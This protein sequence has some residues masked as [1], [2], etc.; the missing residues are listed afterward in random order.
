MESFA[1]AFQQLASIS[2]VLGGLAFTGAAAIL[3]AGAAT[4]DPDVVSRSAEVTAGTAVS[5]AVCFIAAAV[6]WSLMA[7]DVNRAIAAGAAFPDHVANVNW[8]PSLGLLTGTL[9]LLVSIGASGWIASRR[10]GRVTSVVAVVG[11]VALLAIFGWFAE[12]G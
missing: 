5:G 1:E 8:I 11:G 3:N 6:M 12:V 10:L 7:A 9:L 2:A 4:D